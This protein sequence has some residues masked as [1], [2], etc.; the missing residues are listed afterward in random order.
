MSEGQRNGQ[1]VLLMGVSGCG[2][3]T[4]GQR[5]AEEAGWEFYDG[6][7]FHPEVNIEKMASGLALDDEDRQGRLSFRVDRVNAAAV[8]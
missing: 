1:L 7:D 5:L 8:D 3:T 2:K 4:I 6:D